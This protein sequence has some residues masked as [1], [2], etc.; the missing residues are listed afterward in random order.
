ML[1]RAN[2]APANAI[3]LIVIGSCILCLMLMLSSCGR[4]L[5]DDET[6]EPY[7]DPVE[8]FDGL[9]YIPI[10]EE[11][12]LIPGKT[13]LKGTANNF[14]GS[15]CC[16]VLHS[17]LNAEPWSE[18]RHD[19]MYWPAGPGRKLRITIR[20]NKAFLQEHFHEVPHS[21]RF[22]MEFL[23]E[24]SEQAHQ[25]LRQ[26]REKESGFSEKGREMY[27]KEFGEKALKVALEKVGKARLDNVYFLYV[28]NSKVK[29][30]IRC[31]DTNRGLYEGCYLS[32]PW[33]KSLEVE[34]Y[35]VRDYLDDIVAQADKIVEK[36]KEFE[37]AGFAYKQT[38]EL[39]QNNST[40]T[41]TTIKTAQQ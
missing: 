41:P 29:Y 35:F 20:G 27:L 1:K 8:K 7:I 30:N 11:V 6:K 39:K 12:F 9:S 31:D 34:I 25:G 33:G 38:K 13:W 22:R 18:E 15:I 3:D 28:E 4:I 2:N 17:T 14:D 16:I 10:D 24:E 40:L 21:R 36:L 19:D 37:Q 26:F 5:G 23:E 32:F